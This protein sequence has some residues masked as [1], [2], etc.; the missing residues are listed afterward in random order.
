MIHG[1][2]IIHKDGKCLL[3]REYEKFNINEQLFSG[4]LVAILSFSK[5]ISKRALKHI[6]L[7]DL[8]LYYENFEDKKLVFVIAADSKERES[9][10]RKKISLIEKAFFTKYG[11]VLQNWRGNITIFSNFN[12]KID[13]IL[14]SKGFKISISDLKIINTTPFENLFGKLAILF[15]KNNKK[16]IDE[17]E[18]T[19]EVLDRIC[20][21]RAPFKP[22]HFLIDPPKKVGT[23]LKKIIEK[24]Y[25][26]KD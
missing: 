17:L 16:E 10:I 25:R 7:E 14:H 15:G 8:T 19:V 12:S 11:E 3:F 13:E 21:Q 2:W 9:A 1:V 6:S 24:I 5:E 20:E 26:K 18:H 22:P 23:A 4:F